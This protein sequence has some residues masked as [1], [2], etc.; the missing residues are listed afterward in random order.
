MT[1][2]V[3]LAQITPIWLNRSATLEKMCA[4]VSEAAQN[5]AG[6]EEFGKALLPGYPY[7]PEMTEGSEYESDEQKDLFSHKPANAD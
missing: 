5:G 1:L 2:K 7:W 6:L 3:A 4:H